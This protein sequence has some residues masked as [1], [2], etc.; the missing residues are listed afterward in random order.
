[1]GDAADWILEEGS[2]SECEWCGKF[3]GKHA[4]DCEW[5]AKPSAESRRSP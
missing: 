2:M 5:S 4:K 1:M 3:G